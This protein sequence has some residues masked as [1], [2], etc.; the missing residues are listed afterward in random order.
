MSFGVAKPKKLFLT[1][2]FFKNFLQKGFLK[3]KP[4]QIFLKNKKKVQKTPKPDFGKFNFFFKKPPVLDF[5]N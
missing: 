2:G 1:I 3:F 5:F 4:S